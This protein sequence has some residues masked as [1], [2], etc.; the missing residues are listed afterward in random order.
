MVIGEGVTVGESSFIERSVI[1]KGCRIGAGVSIVD[2]HV[3]AGAEVEDG[4]SLVGAIVAS[5]A[6]SKSPTGTIWLSCPLCLSY[7]SFLACPSCPL[8]DVVRRKKVFSAEVALRK[9]PFFG[10][11]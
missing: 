3:W 4:A 9:L 10:R 2:S 1:G 5:R 7:P 8:L 6:M 11:V